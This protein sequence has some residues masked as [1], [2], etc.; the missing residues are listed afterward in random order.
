MREFINIIENISLSESRGLGARKP[1]EEFVSK[2][3]P[4]DK[5]YVDSVEFY[6]ADHEA[7]ASYEEMVAELQSV[8]QAL[9]RRAYV[10]LI[11]KFKPSDRAFGV[12]TF[13]REDN[14]LVAFVKPFKNIHLDRTLVNW[15]NQTG[16]PGYRYNSAA[17]AKTQ[18]GATPQDILTQKQSGLTPQDIIQQVAAKFGSDSP[19]TKFVQQI[20]A[21]QKLPVTIPAVPELGFT[22]FRDYF[23]ELVHPIALQTG[24][25]TG[26]AGEAAARFLGKGGFADTSINF[27]KDKTEGLSDSIMIAPDA[28]KIKVSSKG[29]GGAEAS[30]KNLIEAAK[31]LTP[32]Q[33]KKYKET[34]DLVTQVKQSGQSGAPL[35]L[36]VRYG[37]ISQEDAADITALRKLP[38]T[39]MSAAL[40]TG[41]SDNLKKLIK[42]RTP[43]NPDDLNLYFHLMA[44]VAHEVAKYVNENTNFNEAASTILNNGALVQIYTKARDN[45]DTWTV[46]SFQTVWPSSTVSGV[47]FSA[48][49]TY[50]STGIKGNFTFEIL[51]NGAKHIPD[52]RSEHPEMEPIQP[53]A[54]APSAVTGKRVDIRPKGVKRAEPSN[55]LGREKR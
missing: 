51:R 3:N 37:I 23:C 43:A 14:S 53:T 44:A 47:F 48:G 12:A 15:E 7:Y 39:S 28:K 13:K 25:Y 8:T 20:A 1:G 27:G 30:S 26:N 22:A 17:A 38:R 11:G 49:K 24:N 9:G 45:G 10:D 55:N 34:I 54:S 16:I 33:A 6:P 18:A 32:E 5:I 42:G 36:G 41:I 46:T 29:S 50:Y 19:L 35:V 2:T 52:E 21:G 31:E 4:D 40:E